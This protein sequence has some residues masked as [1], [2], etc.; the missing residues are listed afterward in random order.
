MHAVKT[1]P[2]RFWRV[3]GVLPVSRQ[4]RPEAVL[5]VLTIKGLW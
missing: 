2:A 1:A 5:A 4:K 3:F